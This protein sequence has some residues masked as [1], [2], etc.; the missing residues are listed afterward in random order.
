M[1]HAATVLTCLA[2]VCGA[3]SADQVTIRNIP[4]ANVRITDAANC[5]ITYE[6]QGRSYD[7]PCTDVNY[8]YVASLPALTKAEDLMKAGKPTEA[9]AAYDKVGF[10]EGA[11]WAG[12]LVRYRRLRAADAARAIDRAVEDWLA[13]VKECSASTASAA[14]V[15]KGLGKRRSQSNA[16]AIDLLEEALKQKGSPAFQAAAKELLTGLYELEGMTAKAAALSGGTVG[17]A[18]TAAPTEVTVS[19]GDLGG[20]L[21]E[22]A[23]QIK[24][25]Q[26]AAAADGI[27]ARIRRY[28]DNELPTALLLRGKA[29]LMMYEKGAAKDRKT[30]LEAGL[31]FMR[32]AGCIS[33]GEPEV[34]EATFLAAKVCEHLDNR[35]AAANAYRLILQRHPGTEWA[36]RAQAALAPGG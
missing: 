29:L 35:V 17:N 19:A 27:K 12:R 20:Q 13:I 36:K 5:K 30:L 8:V 4:Y 3:V 1:R 6:V 14:L 22:A 28:S 10:A 7:K 32:V 11:E 15:P 23:N 33:P 26:Y 9:L 34:P 25:G 18:D 21:G 24:A 2:A 16:D 31:C